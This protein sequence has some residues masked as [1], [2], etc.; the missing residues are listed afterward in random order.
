[1]QNVIDPL[2]NSLGV[3]NKVNVYLPYDPEITHWDIYPRE[4]KTYQYVHIHTH[5]LQVNAYSC[6]ISNRSKLGTQQMA[7]RW[8]VVHT[9]EETLLSNKTG[10]AADKHTWVHAFCSVRKTSLARLNMYESTSV[11][12]SKGKSTGRRLVTLRVEVRKDIFTEVW[13]KVWG[14]GDAMYLEYSSG[15]WLWGLVGTHRTVLYSLKMMNSIVCKWFL[16]APDRIAYRISIV[17]Q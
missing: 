1:M 17:R 13:E 4:I 8:C 11:T 15:M 12:F 14:E 10:Q 5:T 7:I 6:F 3:F 16:N 9:H 2:E